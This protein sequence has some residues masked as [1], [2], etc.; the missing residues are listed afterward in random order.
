[1]LQ[2]RRS[3]WCLQ[4]STCRPLLRPLLLRLLPLLLLL[5]PLLLPSA[6]LL[7]FFSNRTT[8]L[9]GAVILLILLSICRPLPCL[10]QQRR[11]HQR[12]SP[13]VQH[14]VVLA[15]FGVLCTGREGGAKRCGDIAPPRLRLLKMGRDDHCATRIFSIAARR[16]FGLR[17]SLSCL[18]TP[19]THPPAHSLARTRGSRHGRSSSTPGP[20]AARVGPAEE[21]A[22]PP[23][24]AWEESSWTGGRWGVG[25]QKAAQTLTL[26]L[27]CLPGPCRTCTRC[28][29]IHSGATPVM[30]ANKRVRP[31][32]APTA[33]RPSQATLHGQDT[34][35]RG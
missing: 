18:P 1:M 3:M 33:A 13:L 5:R 16:L 4:I 28:T 11:Q 32:C 29:L 26:H 6:P 20:A 7:P 23:A 14:R 8:L 24:W 27:A 35:P 12:C 34:Q 2:P 19:T 9:A 25:G 15:A 21:T 17:V 22:G 10:S 30:A 31:G